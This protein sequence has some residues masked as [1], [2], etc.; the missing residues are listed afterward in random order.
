MTTL[1]IKKS[2]YS[3]VLCF[4]LQFVLKHVLICRK[5]RCSWRND[6]MFRTEAPSYGF[7][8]LQWVKDR[9]KVALCSFTA[10]TTKTSIPSP[11]FSF[12][13]TE[14]KN[15]QILLDQPRLYWKAHF[16]SGPI[17]STLLGP[18][19]T[20]RMSTVQPGHQ[21]HSICRGSLFGSGIWS[22]RDMGRGSERGGTPWRSVCSR[23]PQC[24]AAAA[25]LLKGQYNA[26]FPW[27]STSVLFR[28]QEKLGGDIHAEI[29]DCLACFIRTLA[30]LLENYR[31][32][33]LYKQFQSDFP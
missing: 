29:P 31:Q 24:Q 6:K 33:W 11:F 10:Q 4:L 13:T 1:E 30:Y 25:L 15:L 18:G 16:T 22:L 32:Y 17:Q 12:N 9:P 8:H 28:G 20:E 14:E 21:R 7:H 5:D 2:L 23:L 27:N 19:N 3:G 26:S